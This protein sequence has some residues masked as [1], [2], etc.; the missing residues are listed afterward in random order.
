MTLITKSESYL[1]AVYGA[2]IRR[3]RA[4]SSEDQAKGQLKKEAFLKVRQMRW[5]HEDRLLAE[6]P[7]EVWEED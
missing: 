1:D 5:A 4:L 2:A 6:A 7:R 3:E